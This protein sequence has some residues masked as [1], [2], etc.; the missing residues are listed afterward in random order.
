MAITEASITPVVLIFGALAAMAIAIFGRKGIREG[1]RD[2]VFNRR[3]RMVSGIIGVV[4][5]AWA[6]LMIYEG[7]WT[8]FLMLLMFVLLG[9]GL[10]LPILPTTNLGT[11]IALIIAALVGYGLGT[12]TDLNIWIVII[13]VLIVFFTLFLIFR[14][15]A[16]SVKLM[17]TT[18]GARWVLL[19]L[20]LVS[21]GIGIWYL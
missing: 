7:T 5:I 17:G 13:V 20:G 8:Q 19:V 10:L 18:I 15:L 1:K 2:T 3:L 16:A 12:S 11:I 21:I 14:V 4:M 9:I 6:F